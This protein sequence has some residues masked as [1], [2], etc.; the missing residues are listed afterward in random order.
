MRLSPLTDIAAHIVEKM[1]GHLDIDGDKHLPWLDIQSSSPMNQTQNANGAALPGQD[2]TV[3]YGL[4]AS[5]MQ[6]G[7]LAGGQTPG[8]GL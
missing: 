2:P 7:L 1:T 8:G 5:Q 6:F 4:H 3:N